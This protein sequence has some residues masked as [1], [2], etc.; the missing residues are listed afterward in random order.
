MEAASFFSSSPTESCRLHHLLNKIVASIG[1]QAQLQV[2]SLV[3]TFLAC[4]SCEL[5]SSL[6]R[7]CGRRGKREIND[8]D[9]HIWFTLKSLCELDSC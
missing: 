1:S 6:P 9:M 7:C 2:D 3:L 8:A 4:A 5:N